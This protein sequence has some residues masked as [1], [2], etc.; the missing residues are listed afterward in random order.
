[1]RLRFRDDAVTLHAL[2]IKTEGVQ[3]VHGTCVPPQIVPF[4]LRF[5]PDAASI[6]SFRRRF[7]G[8]LDARGLRP[9]GRVLLFSARGQI[10]LELCLDD[11]AYGSYRTF[12]GNAQTVEVAF[13]SIRI[14]N[15]MPNSMTTACIEGL[16]SPIR[17]LNGS[18]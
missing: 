3:C 11:G 17:R 9:R 15:G 5:C 4:V 1:M 8:T 10:R 18:D 16:L 13:V 14:G 2:S 7:A 12:T 6:S